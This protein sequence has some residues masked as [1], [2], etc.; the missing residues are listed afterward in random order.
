[1]P[2]L[3]KYKADRTWITLT[4]ACRMLELERAA[5]PRILR[6]AGVRSRCLPGMTFPQW[7]RD[8][9]EAL[10]TRV[11]GPGVATAT[12]AGAGKR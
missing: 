10:A 5:A 1:M 7:H 11:E 6:A 2:R 3:V 9:C 12:K 4:A 8:D